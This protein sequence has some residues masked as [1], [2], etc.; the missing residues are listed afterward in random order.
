MEQ[1]A[2]ERNI[3][4]KAPRERVWRAITDPEQVEQWFSPGTSWKSSGSGVGAKLYVQGAGSAELYTQIME[5]Y[6]PPRRVAMRS[7]DTSN[8]V[9]WTL[10]EED[11]GTR[12]TVTESGFAG[13]ADEIRQQRIEQNAVGFGMLLENLQAHVEGRQLPYPQGF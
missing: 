9:T 8:V 6:D 13:L 10:V 2:V 4:I 11:G 1:V 12:V 7:L 3:W 5:V